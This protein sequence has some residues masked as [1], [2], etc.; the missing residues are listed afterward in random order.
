MN[1][2]LISNARF[3]GLTRVFPPNRLTIA[4]VVLR[5]LPVYI[6]FTQTQTTLR[7]TCVV[8]GR[9]QLRAAL[10]VRTGETLTGKGLFTFT[11][12]ELNWTE[13][14]WPSVSRPS[15]ATVTTRSLVTR[16]S[17]STWLA[18]AKLGLLVLSD[19]WTHVFRCGCWHWSLHTPVRELELV[20]FSSRPKSC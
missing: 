11:T 6:K 2:H 3:L 18:A 19:F 1:S 20:R 9:I 12:H 14:N 4:S 7:R 13:L 15:Y 5:D 17:V 16:A 10:M 8:A